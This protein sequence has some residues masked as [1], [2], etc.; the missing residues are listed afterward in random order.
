MSLKKKAQ[1]NTRPTASNAALTQA[2]LQQLQA[3]AQN[4]PGMQ[5]L[6]DVVMIVSRTGI[7]PGELVRLSWSSVDLDKGQLVV[8]A[9]IG[10]RMVPFEAESRKAFAALHARRPESDLVLGDSASGVHC[11]M[12][13][14][15]RA[16]SAQIGMSPATF[17]SIRHTFFT[18]LSSAGVPPYVL[19][20]I[21]G[22]KSLNSHIHYFAVSGPVIQH[23]YDAALEKGL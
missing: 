23:N 20:A 15:L 8:D 13:R 11:R 12:S 10:T 19:M 2:E 7:R 4:T 22:W 21:A 6:C 17:H 3:A 14:Q 9:K 18:H 1:R 16:L 5:D